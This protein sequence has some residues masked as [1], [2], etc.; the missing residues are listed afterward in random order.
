MVE[1]TVPVSQIVSTPITNLAPCKLDI[2][3]ERRRKARLGDCLA[4]QPIDT[5]IK[6][7]QQ[8]FRREN[9]DRFIF[10]WDFVQPVVLS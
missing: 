9:E 6:L 7:P 3:R 5:L 1:N 4:E 8:P 10:Y 2:A